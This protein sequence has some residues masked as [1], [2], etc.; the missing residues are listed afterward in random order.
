MEVMK[1]LGLVLRDHVT[2]IV[3]GCRNHLASLC[4]SFLTWN[5]FNSS[6]NI[7]IVRLTY[8]PSEH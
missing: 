8:K 2:A 3:M 7:V 4:L 1:E 6:T 5:Q